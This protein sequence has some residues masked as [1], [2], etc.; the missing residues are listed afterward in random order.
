MKKLSFKSKWGHK[1]KNIKEQ[2]GEEI[3]I[4]RYE[5]YDVP[6]SDMVLK[7]IEEAKEIFK[8]ER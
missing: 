5:P 7:A 3:S 1:L 4:D 6:Y 2:I 8:Y